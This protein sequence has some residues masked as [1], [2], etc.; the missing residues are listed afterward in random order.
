M[1]LERSETLISFIQH[2]FDSVKHSL[3][4]LQLDYIDLLQCHRFDPDTPVKET[5]QA[6]HDVVKAGYVGYV[7]MSSCYA[8]QFPKMQHYALSHDLTP[9]FSMLNLHNAVYREEE[10][11]MIPMLKDLSVGRSQKDTWLWVNGDPK[12]DTFLATINQR[13]KEVA[14]KRELTMAQVAL[15]WSLSKDFVTSPVIGTT[16]LDNLDE[17]AVAAR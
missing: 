8:W 2:I 1:E 17:L 5:M 15:A 9:F 12:V 10:R 14:D 11:E 13:V 3:E 16:R 4:R 6:L 7:G